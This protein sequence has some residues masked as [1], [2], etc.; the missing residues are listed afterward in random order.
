MFRCKQFSFEGFWDHLHSDRLQM[1]K[2]RAQLLRTCFASNELECGA[3]CK[4]SGIETRTHTQTQHKGG[5]KLILV[6]TSKNCS[7]SS[8][9]KDRKSCLLSLSIPMKFPQNNILNLPDNGIFETFTIVYFGSG[10]ERA[11]RSATLITGTL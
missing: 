1:A 7:L 3:C 11:D 2:C 9:I 5:G 4:C 6:K 8:R 10:S